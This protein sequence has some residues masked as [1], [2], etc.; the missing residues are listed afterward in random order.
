MSM[1]NEEVKNI[2]SSYEVYTQGETEKEIIFP[3]ACHN[4]ENGS[5]K[6][7]YF[8]DEKIFRCFT[9]CTAMFDIFDLIQK[10]EKLRGREISLPKAMDIA[11]VEQ[12]GG[13]KNE[14]VSDLQY[15]KRLQKVVGP[16]EEPTEVRIL[17]KNILESFSVADNGLQSWLQE[18]ISMESILKFKIKYDFTTNAIIIPNFD[19][20]GN[21]VGVRGRFLSKNAKA[22][23]MPIFYG[24]QVL[25]HPTGRF[26]YGY[27]ENKKRIREK[28]FVVLFEGEKSVLKMQ[29]IYPDD[30]M[31]LSTSGKKIT[32]DHLNALLK[33]NIGEVVLAYDADY[34][35]DEEKKQKIE[36]YDKIV[37]ILKPYFTVSI[38]VDNG[39]LLNFKDSPIDQG[40]EIFEKLL[41]ERVKR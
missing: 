22:K 17:D 40:Q 29:T 38:M 18:G 34:Q 33:L 35:N 2:L 15:L 11:G 14:I 6:L 3:T 27:N 23:Y 28:G 21:L 7:Y 37:S 1:T 13:P 39:K 31:S 10:M 9:E 8:K 20:E 41:I 12:K 19:H 26:L 30:N 32:L 4:L 25:S 36:E 5:P 24:G 16:I